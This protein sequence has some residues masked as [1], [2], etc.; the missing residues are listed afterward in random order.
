MLRSY[1]IFLAR[2]T[3]YAAGT[4][5][6]PISLVRDTQI[7]NLPLLFHVFLCLYTEDQCNRLIR[8]AERERERERERHGCTQFY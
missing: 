4:S 1:V 8:P 2:N 3:H 7:C 5:G 6:S